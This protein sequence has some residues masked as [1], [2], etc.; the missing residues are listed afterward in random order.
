MTS[1]FYVVRILLYI[2]VYGRN[3]YLYSK[4]LSANIYEQLLIADEHSDVEY[5]M[6][7]FQAKYRLIKFWSTMINMGMFN[8]D[9]IFEIFDE[10]DKPEKSR[11]LDKE[12]IIKQRCKNH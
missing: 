1:N 9:H 7:H 2:P 10:R 6:L 4:F 11:R 3:W 5:G 8:I 12:D